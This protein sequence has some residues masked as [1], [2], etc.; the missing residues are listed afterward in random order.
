MKRFAT[1]PIRMFGVDAG[2]INIF[3]KMNHFENQLNHLSF[4]KILVQV[5]RFFDFVLGLS[6]VARNV[7][8]M[9]AHVSFIEMLGA[10]TPVCTL[11]VN[12]ALIGDVELPIVELVE[13]KF[14]KFSGE[15]RDARKIYVI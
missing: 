3:D 9:H 7:A 11:L 14:T 15:P 10:L 8:L 6:L 12:R 1:N 13:E 2:V 5:I 4:L